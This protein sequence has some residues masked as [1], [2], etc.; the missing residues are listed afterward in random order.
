[1][2]VCAVV[3]FAGRHIHRF[4]PAGM[5]ARIECGTADDFHQEMD[6]MDAVNVM[7]VISDCRLLS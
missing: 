2:S 4:H 7:N 1:M 5:K 6:V 3:V